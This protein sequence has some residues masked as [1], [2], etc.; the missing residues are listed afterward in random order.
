M[1]VRA[2]TLATYG[3]GGRLDM[4]KQALEPIARMRMLDVLFFSR[5]YCQCFSSYVVPLS[6]HS[7]ELFHLMALRGRARSRGLIRHVS[8][9]CEIA[10]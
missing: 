2:P 5:S 7:A 8:N 4:A 9:V 10:T 1:H 6:R 3:G